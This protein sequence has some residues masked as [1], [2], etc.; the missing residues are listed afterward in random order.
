MNKYEQRE[1]IELDMGE[2][3]GGFMDERTPRSRIN[4]YI[5]CFPADNWVN[6]MIHRY[7]EAKRDEN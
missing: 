3:E 7:N 1:V 2:F 5:K 6:S 4:K